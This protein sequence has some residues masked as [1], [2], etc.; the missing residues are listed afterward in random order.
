MRRDDDGEVDDVMAGEGAAGN[1]FVIKVVGIGKVAVVI[2][3]SA[4]R[5]LEGARS[6]GARDLTGAGRSRGRCACASKCAAGACP[7][8]S[9]MY[10]WVGTIERNVGGLRGWETS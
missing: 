7:L 3:R 8:E 4:M 6:A 2:R 1:A 5:V 10:R 9:E